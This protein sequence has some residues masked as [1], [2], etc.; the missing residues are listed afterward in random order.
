MQIGTFNI[1]GVRKNPPN[2]A[3]GIGGSAANVRQ[4]IKLQ[5]TDILSLTELQL[6]D[7]SL[8]NPGILARLERAM[9]ARAAQW[10][11][12]C[13]VM[14]TNPNLEF[15]SSNTY[16]DGRVIV[17][18]IHCT[19]TDLQWDL[20]TIYAPAQ[21]SLRVPFYS[22]IIS[23]PFFTSPP[24]NFMLMGDLNIQP[25][26]FSKYTLFNTWITSHASNCITTGFSTPLSTFRSPASGNRSTLD[27]I[28]SSPSLQPS[29]SSPLHFFSPFSDHDLVT[30]SF[31]P[32]PST[33]IGKGVWRL[34]TSLLDNKDFRSGLE[35]ALDKCAFQLRTCFR[36]LSKQEQWDKVKKKIKQ[37]CV[38]AS[39]EAKARKTATIEEYEAQRRQHKATAERATSTVEERKEA[40]EALA[41]CEEMIDFFTRENLNGIAFRAGVQWQEKGERNT[42]YFFNTLRQRT[43]K[44]HIPALMDPTNNTKTT[45]TNGM[46]DIATSFYTKLYTPQPSCLLATQYLTNNLN[47]STP[48][49]Q[50][51]N[52][53]L[54]LP[55][56]SNT[57]D[58]MLTFTPKRRSPGK[59]GLPF[60]IYPQL[61]AH[62]EIRDL[63]LDVVNEA[64]EQG[65]F[66]DTWHETIMILLF[67]KG[68]A[69]NLANWRP[70]SLINSDAKLFTKLL[71]NRLRPL[72]PQLIHPSQTGFMKGRF[73]ADNG[74]VLSTVMDHCKAE[75]EKQIGIML[76]FEKAYDRV[77]P[78]YLAAVL[79]TM[80]FA[81][82][83]IRIIHSLFFET[84]IHLN[85]NGHIAPSITQGRGLRQG[86]PLSPLL[87]NIALEP[88]L[89]TIRNRSDLHGISTLT[90]VKIV[91]MAY[92]DDVLLLLNNKLEW[93]RIQ[94]ILQLYEAASNGRVNYNKTTAFPLT[95]QPDQD[96]KTALLSDSVQWHDSDSPSPL[97]YLGY[98]V[99]ICQAQINKYLDDL[100]SKIQRSINIHSQR[101]LSVLGKAVI[102]NSLI[103][104]RLWH[105]LWVISPP[106]S[107]FKKVVSI[108][109]PFI[110]PNRPAPAWRLFC[111][112]K[113]QGG[114]GIIDPGTQA[115]TFQLRHVQNMLSDKPS[116]G[117]QVMLSAVQLYTHSPSPF[118][119]FLSP[120]YYLKPKAGM[121][122][123]F[124]CPSATLQSLLKAFARLPRFS[125]DYNL[126]E[127][128]KPPIELFLAS[129]IEWWLEALPTRGRNIPPDASASQVWRP[130]K[131][132]YGLW[133][134]E[135]LQ[136]VKGTIT[137]QAPLPLTGP[138]SGSTK[139]L[140]RRLQKKSTRFCLQV[141]E[142]VDIPD[143]SLRKILGAIKLPVGK[144]DTI[145]FVQASTQQLRSFLLPPGQDRSTA[146]KSHWRAFWKANIQA[147]SRNLW[148]RTI[149]H[150]IPTAAFRFEKWHTAP[151]PECPVCH[152][153]QEDLY[154]YI[155]HCPT[156]R[157]AWTDLLHNYTDKVDWTDLEL[158]NLLKP[159]CP[160]LQTII[161][162][163]YSIK[164]HQLVASGLHGIWS[165]FLKAF[166]ENTF[167][168]STALYNIMSN[169]AI[170]YNANNAYFTLKK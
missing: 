138:R 46:I 92:A 164:A 112:P 133:T 69:S 84:R 76:D 114:L 61:L 128:S 146:K 23:L 1:R 10:S 139:K 33:T 44:R 75:E 32:T 120:N 40:M 72:L 153:P 79:T 82:T 6:D 37:F 154:H 39:I 9:G 96:L 151:S 156:K 81:P 55:L 85:I 150:A 77:N 4:W 102:V 16:L 100:L 41:V 17:A 170:R 105:T 97:I 56:T 162:K 141:K 132:H 145:S 12:H 70:L 136:V 30:T 19:F 152:A 50:Q 74:L 134:K 103:L 94:V 129:P 131:D 83:F 35:L 106:E 68:D 36:G 88:L 99:P 158:E 90:A 161:Q 113:E 53:S 66:P 119:V 165:Y 111:S 140:I 121:V 15:I 49:Q 24:Q 125:W 27:Y 107:W 52:T 7:S 91:L 18:T 59:D 86:D 160:V 101:T 80:G 8:Q 11:K 38:T 124:H 14:L 123:E 163:K 48:L 130:T 108:I 71:T 5:R 51:D 115:I 54:L 60:E 167:L 22:S 148:W 25:H 34:N 13:C 127:L 29:I 122:K 159:S 3:S 149:H 143:L 147:S 62:P 64:L 126:P 98:P 137:P 78:D 28:F 169:S 73:I 65:V 45:N 144:K 93:R 157:E 57:L 168:P 26:N 118:S 47:H 117:R 67:K 58:T 87:F 63:F 142:T 2:S 21:H 155:F 166:L 135:L 42:Q 116:F 20:C 95:L 89:Q 109:K 31:A 110:L 104:S 43:T